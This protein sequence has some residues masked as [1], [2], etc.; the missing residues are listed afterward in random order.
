MTKPSWKTEG[1]EER[2]EGPGAANRNNS[3]QDSFS[4]FGKH[5]ANLFKLT[6]RIHTCTKFCII[7][8]FYR[9][10]VF[11]RSALH[12]N[13]KTFV[14]SSRRRVVIMLSH[15]DKSG[16]RWLYCQPNGRSPT[17][18]C[19]VENIHDPQQCGVAFIFLL[20]AN[21]LDASQLP[22]IKVSLLLHVMNCR[23]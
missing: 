23:F 2:R 8:S 20:L 12:L 16:T 21:E 17:H 14:T 3:V 4:D 10:L 11:N 15:F 18:I 9:N 5:L 6:H 13:K 22:K 1:G 7:C 19:G